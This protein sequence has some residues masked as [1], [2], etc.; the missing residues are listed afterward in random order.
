MH[1]RRLSNTAAEIKGVKW[2]AWRT[3]S[4]AHLIGDVM[5]INNNA[6]FLNQSFPRM[7]HHRRWSTETLAKKKW[8]EWNVWTRVCAA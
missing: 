2:N 3:V 5:R 6:A 8:I 1:C 4:H 7:L